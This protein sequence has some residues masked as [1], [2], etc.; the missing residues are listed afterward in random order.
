VTQQYPYQYQPPGPAYPNPYVQPTQGHWNTYPPHAAP[1]PAAAGPT[2]QV[3]PMQHTGIV[4]VWLN[5]RYTVTGSFAQ[6][7]AA[8]KAAQRH[9]LVAG[10]WSF[11]SVVLWNWI[12]IFTNINQ[13]K[14][15]HRNAAQAQAATGWAAHYSAGYPPQ[16]AGG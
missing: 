5:R 7:E 13:R 16:R 15:L 9:N 6:C 8:I 12:A 2:F 1:Q 11:A 10:W 14:Q 4:I 3:R